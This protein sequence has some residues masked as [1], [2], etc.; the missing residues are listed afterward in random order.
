MQ[1]PRLDL[2][3]LE[4]YNTEASTIATGTSRKRKRITS[5]SFQ[6]SELFTYNHFGGGQRDSDNQGWTVSCF[7]VEFDE[8]GT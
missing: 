4:F 2:R 6:L 5:L 1:P 8:G 7:M 3:V